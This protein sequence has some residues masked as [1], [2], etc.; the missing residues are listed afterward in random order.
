MARC[1]PVIAIAATMACGR[2]GFDSAAQRDA[3]PQSDGTL[4]SNGGSGGGSGCSAAPPFIYL[5]S[6]RDEGTDG[7]GTFP[8]TWCSA[9]VSGPL[10]I[11]LHRSDGTLRL[12]PQ[13]AEVESGGTQFVIGDS[14]CVACFLRLEV[15]GLVHDG[16]P[17]L[18]VGM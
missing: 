4:P 9:G 8:V 10:M 13:T 7:Q 15:S 1:W 5:V 17:A 14:L 11:S 12:M 18:F 6:P 16:P 3:S 2:V